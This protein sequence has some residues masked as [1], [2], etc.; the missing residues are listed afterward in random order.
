LRILLGNSI[1]ISLVGQKAR[2]PAN[3]FLVVRTDICSITSLNYISPYSKSPL[4][5]FWISSPR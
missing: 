3:Y 2:G 5:M 4:R 1:E